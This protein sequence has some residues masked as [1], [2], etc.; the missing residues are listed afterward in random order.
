MRLLLRFRAVRDVDAM[1][2]RAMDTAPSD[3]MLLLLK[4]RE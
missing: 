3:P 2:M 4:N 1:T